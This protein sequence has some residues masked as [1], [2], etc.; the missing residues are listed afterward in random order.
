MTTGRGARESRAQGDGR[1]VRGMTPEREVCSV[2]TAETMLGIIRD[3]GPGGVPLQRRYPL[4]DTPNLS[5]RADARLDAHPGARTP[6]TP[7]E[8]VD[9]LSR[10]NI[11]RLIDAL[12]QERCRW[13]PGRRVH[14]PQTSGKRRPLGLPTW[15][16]KRRHAVIR[17]LR[18]AYCEPQ[19]SAHAHGCRPGRGGHTA[20]RAGP[21]GWTGTQWCIEGEITGCFDTIDPAVLVRVLGEQSHDHRF[22]GL[23]RRRRQAGDVEDWR[24][25]AT[26][27]GTPHGRVGSPLFAHLYVNERER[28]V[29]QERLPSDNRGSRRQRHPPYETRVLRAPRWRRRGRT[30]AARAADQAARPLPSQRP[31]APNDRRLHDVR[32]ADDWLR[33]VAGPKGAADA[34]R[35]GLRAF[36]RQHLQL[37]LSEDTTL[38]THA[39]SQAARFLGDEISRRHA[40]DKR[41]ARGRRRVNGHIMLQGPWDV[42]TSIGSRYER[43]GTPAARPYRRD[44]DDFRIIGRYGVERRGDVNDDPLAHNVGTRYRRTWTMATSRLK[45]LANTHT[46]RVMKMARPYRANITTPTGGLTCCQAVVER[47]EDKHPLVAQ[48]GGFSRRR[49]KDAV[50]VDQPPPTAYTQ[51]TARLKRRQAETCELCG[52]TRQVEGHHLR[53]LADLKRHGRQEVPRWRRLR[54]AQ[55]RKTLVTCRACHEAIHAGRPTR[56]VDSVSITG[57]P[58]AGN[59]CKRGSAGGR[60]TR[61]G[62]SRPRWR[63]TRL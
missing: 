55:K 20:R 37:A 5:L 56:Q 21:R 7:P 35:E 10:A 1:Q 11:D 31:D 17:A 16:D 23:I 9:G 51:G 53:N 26:R 34:S 22:L 48:F 50:L 61:L 47:G 27:S 41:D 29:A 38:S 8:T 45:T 43:R 60:Q 39:A 18:E 40:D 46:S 30:E 13:T 32:Y 58:R 3:R 15:T 63:P 28:F 2:P 57:E 33:G 49:R 24:S 62:P 36:L 25:G 44:D 42:L 6:G 19:F 52:S 12:R 59:A 14:L 54:A 4:L